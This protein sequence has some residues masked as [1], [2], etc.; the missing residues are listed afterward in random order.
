MEDGPAGGSAPRSSQ[1]MT[2]HV[3]RCWD[4]RSLGVHPGSYYLFTAS[5]RSFGPPPAHLL[6]PPS[7][8][9]SSMLGGTYLRITNDNGL[10]SLMWEFGNQP[11]C[12]AR[13]LMAFIFPDLNASQRHQQRSE[14]TQIRPEQSLIWRL[15]R[16]INQLYSLNE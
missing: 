8:S 14:R 9:S 5:S 10:C 1:M 16:Q 15:L 6:L 12:V 2:F 4:G 3:V 13:A 7:S 11:R